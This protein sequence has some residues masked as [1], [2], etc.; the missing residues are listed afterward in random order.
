MNSNNHK[1]AFTLLEILTVIAIVAMLAAILIPVV[2]NA[3]DSARKTTAS[4]NLRQI[5][6]AYF[7]YSNSDGRPKTINKPTLHE[8]ASVLAEKTD[9]NDPQL[10]I[11]PEDPLV[12]NSPSTTPKYISSLNT[13]NNRYQINN[14]FKNSPLSIT[15]ANNLPPSVN[16]STTPI[17]WTRGLQPNGK[18]NSLSNPKPSPYG[19]KGGFI[20]F[21]DG[22]VSWYSD[23]NEDGGQLIHYITKRPTHNIQEALPSSASILDSTF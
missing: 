3:M 9:L 2:G 4:N 20:A 10:W 17:A 13:Q 15:V 19:D 7:N 8:W 1:S 21:L 18:W 14:D 23:L 12:L 5:A 11:I 22:H 16:P 6:I